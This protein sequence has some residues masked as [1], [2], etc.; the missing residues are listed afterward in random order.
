MTMTTMTKVG[1]P[2]DLTAVNERG[3]LATYRP[4]RVCELSSE[5]LEVHYVRVEWPIGGKG[6]PVYKA[7]LDVIKQNRVV[8]L[9]YYG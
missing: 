9:R 4:C 2:A 8:S 1:R 7:G 6:K 3:H 5:N